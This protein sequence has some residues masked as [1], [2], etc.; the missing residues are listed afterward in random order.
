M[1][2]L[3]NNDPTD[4]NASATSPNWTP[5][6]FDPV[7]NPYPSGK[8]TDAVPTTWEDRT[9]ETVG[10][11][12][13]MTVDYSAEDVGALKIAAAFPVN[14]RDSWMLETERNRLLAKIAGNTTTRSNVYACWMTVGFFAVEP[15]TENSS[16]PCLNEEIGIDNGTNVRHRVFFIV[17]RSIATKYDGPP[18]SE[19]AVSIDNMDLLTKLT[20]IE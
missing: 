14:T 3:V 13:S 17:D 10:I 20:I 2:N 16:V 18:E 4:V 1:V 11:T 8:S 12:P 7:A 15:G 6:L 9:K 19:D 5:R